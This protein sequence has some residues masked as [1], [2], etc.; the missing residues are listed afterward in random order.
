M[1]IQ[2]ALPEL[3]GSRAGK[4][5]NGARTSKKIKSMKCGTSKKDS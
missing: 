5:S 1:R 4:R 3:L 2:E